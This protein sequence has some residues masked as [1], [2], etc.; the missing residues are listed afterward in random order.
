M[1]NKKQA[2]LGMPARQNE[3]NENAL[4]DT[5]VFFLSAFAVADMIYW[6]DFQP[7]AGKP[8]FNAYATE[9][10]DTLVAQIDMPAA[11]A[12]PAHFLA[13][14][15]MQKY[16]GTMPSLE[17][18]LG[19]IGE[20]MESD[21]KPWAKISL[22]K[23]GFSYRYANAGPIS[24]FSQ[25]E[26]EVEKIES[27]YA[28]ANACM[29]FAG[30][31]AEAPRYEKIAAAKS[32]LNRANNKV[33]MEILEKGLY[34]EENKDRLGKRQK[35][36]IIKV[37]DKLIENYEVGFENAA[38]LVH[39]ATVMGSAWA[40]GKPVTLENVL[41]EMAMYPD[42]I[43]LEF[44]KR[45]SNGKCSPEADRLT[46]KAI[47]KLEREVKVMIETAMQAFPQISKNAK[48]TIVKLSGAQP[49]NAADNIVQD[50]Q[51]KL[52]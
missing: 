6:I 17:S 14:H 20:Y 16:T 47:A 39:V 49:G 50:K 18:F 11:G 41:S 26:I 22:G 51:I 19:S 35:A 2:V 46:G 27:A 42:Y 25:A 44:L 36:A 8:S 23:S 4:P 24:E 1:N 7:I 12:I 28:F 37:A 10:L 13:W 30:D 33:L 9:F 21:F 29:Y 32:L 31:Q 15:Y 52:K 34:L 43:A 45:M 40:K 5:E 38:L 48:F 3:N